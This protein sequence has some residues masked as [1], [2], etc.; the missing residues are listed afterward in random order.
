MSVIDY[1][2]HICSKLSI[3]SIVRNVITKSIF[4]F[5]NLVT[6]HKVDLT[7]GDFSFFISIV[8]IFRISICSYIEILLIYRDFFTGISRVRIRKARIIWGITNLTNC[9][10]IIRIVAHAFLC[11]ICYIRPIYIK[12]DTISTIIE[13]IVTRIVNTYIK[14]SVFF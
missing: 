10:R 12:I 8:I 14:Y 6:F 1:R 7:Y 13:L 2:I 4:W 5:Y 9:R 11:Y 3:V